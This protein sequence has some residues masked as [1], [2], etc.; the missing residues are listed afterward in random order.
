MDALQQ[1]IYRERLVAVVIGEEATIEAG[2][3]GEELLDVQAMCLF[4][5]EVAAGERPGSYSH[6]G[7]TAFAARAR[8]QRAIASS[9]R[10]K[11]G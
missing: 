11:R 5:I 6:R 7:A 3:S 10:G 9:L 1:I 4:A 8:G 2:L